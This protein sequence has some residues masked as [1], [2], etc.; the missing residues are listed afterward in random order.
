MGVGNKRERQRQRKI[1][2]DRE[3]EIRARVLI[4]ILRSY[5]TFFHL[6]PCLKALLPVG[7]AT[8]WEPQSSTLE[9]LRSIQDSNFVFLSYNMALLDRPGC[10]GT[11]YLCSAG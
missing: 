5:I 7:G 1:E 8:G 9:A 6:A 10:S 11:L 4:A 2:K 3:T